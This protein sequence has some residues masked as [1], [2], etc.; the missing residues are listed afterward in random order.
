MTLYD[1]FAMNTGWQEDDT[2]CIIFEIAGDENEMMLY[3]A[4]KKYGNKEVKW[5][6]GYTIRLV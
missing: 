5:F 1:L 6:N 3:D 4:L 2:V